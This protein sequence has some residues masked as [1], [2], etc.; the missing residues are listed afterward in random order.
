M[1]RARKGEHV[2]HCHA[3]KFPHR[4]GGGKCR[5][6]TLVEEYWGSSYGTGLCAECNAL[7]FVDGLPCCQVVDGQEKVTV[8]PV[9]QEHILSNEIRLVGKYWRSLSV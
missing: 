5:G 6:F 3:Y 1:R 4:F 8:C 9:W 7:S 2:C